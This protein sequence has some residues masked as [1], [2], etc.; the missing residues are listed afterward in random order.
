MS[1]ILIP[2]AALEAGA[3]VLHA[4]LELFED[5]P[6][7]D[8]S[9]AD[10]DEYRE[11]IRAAFLAM[12]EA[13]EGMKHDSPSGGGVS[14]EPLQPSRIILPLPQEASDEPHP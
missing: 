4:N 14:Q 1:N 12:I 11:Q 10:Q 7:E 8:L 3:R 6:W 5:L 9:D 13:W 2:P